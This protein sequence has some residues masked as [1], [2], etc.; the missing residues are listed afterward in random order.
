MSVT[1]EDRERAMAGAM[2]AIAMEWFHGLKT[3]DEIE[4]IYRKALADARAAGAASR[5]KEVFG[6][7]CEIA[8]LRRAIDARRTVAESQ[9]DAAERESA[10]LRERAETAER[11]RDEARAEV[12]RLAT[13]TEEKPTP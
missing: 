7:T 11:E 13:A 9:R 1:A 12:A 3:D 8:D 6:L 10:A 4:A 2:C 5:D